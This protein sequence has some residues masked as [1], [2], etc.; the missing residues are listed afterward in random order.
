MLSKHGSKLAMPKN[1][2]RFRRAT[3]NVQWGEGVSR[4][5]GHVLHLPKTEGRKATPPAVVGTG[6]WGRSPQRSKILFFF[7]FLF[8]AKLTEF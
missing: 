6:V 7:V 2:I 5:C 4:V 8:L 1:M 3:R